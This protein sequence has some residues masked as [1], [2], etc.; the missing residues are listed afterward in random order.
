MQYVST[1]A[2]LSVNFTDD[3]SCFHFEPWSQVWSFYVIQMTFLAVMFVVEALI[4]DVPPEVEVQMGRSEHVRVMYMGSGPKIRSWCILPTYTHPTQLINK[5][6]SKQL[7]P[8]ESHDADE[9]RKLIEAGALTGLKT[10]VGVVTDIFS[11][12]GAGV[13]GG[14]KIVGNALGLRRRSSK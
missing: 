4:D 2:R 13:A 6:L 9:L 3:A 10:G 7:D 14:G 8:P 11:G 1:E 5:C 12:V